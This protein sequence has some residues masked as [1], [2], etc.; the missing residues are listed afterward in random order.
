MTEYRFEENDILGI[1]KSYKKRMAKLL[2]RKDTGVKVRA[3]QFED[4]T[5]NKK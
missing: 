3:V 2:R 4:I 1:R 5:S